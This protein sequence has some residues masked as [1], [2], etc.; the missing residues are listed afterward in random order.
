LF[1]TVKEFEGWDAHTVLNAFGTASDATISVSMVTANGSRTRVADM[2]RSLKMKVNL[3]KMMKHHKP[4]KQR[5]SN[6]DTTAKI[7]AVLAQLSGKDFTV[8][9][10]AKSDSGSKPYDIRLG[11]NGSVYCTCKGWQYDK[12]GKGCKHIE[13]YRQKVKPISV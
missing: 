1:T 9:A 6:E 2:N 11:S 4:P 5:M 12:T 3:Q 10:K 7:K 8:L 13:R